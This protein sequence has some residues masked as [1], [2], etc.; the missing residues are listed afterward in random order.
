MD[1]KIARTPRLAPRCCLYF[2]VLPGLE[3]GTAQLGVGTPS[4]AAVSRRLHGGH[5][6]LVLVGRSMGTS[7]CSS[8]GRHDLWLVPA[9]LRFL[10]AFDLVSVHLFVRVFNDGPVQTSLGGKSLGER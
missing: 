3:I 8:T 9:P 4:G 5:A 1:N 2:L 10:F 6:A 7:I